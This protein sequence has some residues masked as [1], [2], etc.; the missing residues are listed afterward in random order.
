MS[1]TQVYEMSAFLN[2]EQLQF[3]QRALWELDK[4]LTY[5]LDEDEHDGND[6]IKE[7]R[8]ENI[9]K[10]LMVK[11]IRICLLQEDLANCE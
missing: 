11:S 4:E 2:H 1:S 9:K 3:L 6:D 7:K 5:L 10:L 8:P